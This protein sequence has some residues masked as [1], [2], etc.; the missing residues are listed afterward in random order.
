MYLSAALGVAGVMSFAGAAHAQPGAAP[1][2]APPAAAATPAATRPTI[3]VFNM[4]AVMRE[5]GQAKYQVHLLTAKKTQ[6]S[7]HLMEMRAE[8][9]QI[10]QDLQKN[11]AA[12]D[13]DAKEARRLKLVRDI[14]DED[15]KIS[16]ELN[17][18]ASAIIGDL[19]D[20]MKVVVDKTAEINGYHI[21]FAYPDAVTPEEMK[22]PYMKEL[23]LKPPA[24]QPF[25]VAPHADITAMIVQT[26]NKWYP[27][28]DPVTKQVIDVSKLPEQSAAPSTTPA[29][30]GAP[31]PGAVPGGAP[32]PGAVP[33][34]R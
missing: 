23:K 15:R 31:Q 32:R 27:P 14:E 1:A 18:S 30:G 12:P 29:P 3:A 10:T 5:F 21:V 26:L 28:V 6:I 17:E 11:P 19:Y 4:A 25:Y 7:K 24:A 34:Q 33:G 22:N 8:Y 2:G 13:K 9:I 16:K 20:K